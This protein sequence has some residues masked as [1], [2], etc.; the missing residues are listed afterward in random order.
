MPDLNDLFNLIAEETRKQHAIKAE[1]QIIETFSKLLNDIA[2]KEP[3][4][5]TIDEVI[6]EEVE[7]LPL[8]EKETELVVEETLDTTDNLIV[9]EENIVEKILEE[10]KEI[11]EAQLGL[12]G[13]DTTTKTVDPITPL[14][15]N[16]VTFD[17]LQKHYKLYLARIQQQLSTLGGGGEVN[18]RYLDD[19]D[20]STIFDGRFLRYNNAKKKFEFVEVNPVDIIY[21]TNL[22]ETPTYVVDGDNY[23]IGVNYDGPVEITLPL[24]PNSGRMLIIKDESGNA[25]TNPITV[26]G[27][28]DNDPGGF[29]IQINNGAVQLIY[30][31]GWRIV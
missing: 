14:N 10:K 3:H 29:I 22:V 17:D 15:Q 18:L 25:E 20:R 16:F 21:T 13:G 12:I 8:E 1:N 31:N 5:L 30:R 23:Y 27:N 19:V 4:D 26:L 2:A 6:S 28:V 7:E 24:S 9:E 11:K